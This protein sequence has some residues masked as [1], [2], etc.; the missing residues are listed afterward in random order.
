MDSWGIFL[1]NGP[2]VTRM[3]R[4]HRVRTG[5]LIGWFKPGALHPV[6]TATSEALTCFCAFTAVG[7][8]FKPP[9]YGWSLAPIRRQ[10]LL[11]G[12]S[13]D[14]TFNDLQMFWQMSYLLSAIKKC[15]E[16]SALNIRKMYAYRQ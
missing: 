12:L 15:Q 4:H 13:C 11:G 1:I 14:Y 16:K 5:T 6:A 3:E 9:A 10:R 7:R 8:K 2:P